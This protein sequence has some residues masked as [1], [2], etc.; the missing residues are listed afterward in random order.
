MTGAEGTA[1]PVRSP[2]EA[3]ADEPEGDPGD[4][5][6][7]PTCTYPLDADV[8]WHIRT[9]EGTTCRLTPLSAP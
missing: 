2:D 3:R 5:H 8:P 9:P 7:C 4:E 6:P 1:E